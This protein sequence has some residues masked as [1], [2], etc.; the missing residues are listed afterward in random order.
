M[1]FRDIVVVAFVL[2]VATA[3]S[4]TCKTEA[5]CPKEFPVVCSLFS[6]KK[7]QILV[8]Q[9]ANESNSAVGL[10]LPTSTACRKVRSARECGYKGLVVGTA[11]SVGV[12]KC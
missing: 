1:N 6:T 10:S 3:Q 2:G 5:D 9:V 7:L 11:G 12:F 4:K 8:Y